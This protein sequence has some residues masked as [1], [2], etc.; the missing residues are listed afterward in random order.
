MKKVLSAIDPKSLADTA[1]SLSKKVASAGTQISEGTQKMVAQ[2]LD[3]SKK[4][5]DS[6]LAQVSEKVMS[7]GVQITDD[8]HHLIE[9]SMKGSKTKIVDTVSRTKEKFVTRIQTTTDTK[10]LLSQ[11]MDGS[12]EKM[13]DTVKTIS[14]KVIDSGVQASEDAKKIVDQSFDATKNKIGDLK[15]LAHSQFSSLHFNISDAA[16]PYIATLHDVIAK[17]KHHFIEYRG[18]TGDL[19]SQGVRH[20]AQYIRQVDPDGRYRENLKSAAAAIG[21]ATVAGYDKIVTASPEFLN[22]SQSLKIKLA[23]AG[24]RDSAWRTIPVAE[25]FYES[26]IPEAVRNLGNDAVVEFLQGKHASHITS[27]HND[28]SQSMADGNIIW[29]SVHEN[30]SRGS[31]NMTGQNLLG[32]ICQI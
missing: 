7:N 16:E 17:G 26:S 31:A 3:V 18:D 20:I 32:G 9:H 8:T 22:L 27:V 28:I 24:L 19:I 1:Q 12:M 29:E 10:N 15:T 6:A 23:T 21:V 11:S 4:K 30:L 2:S 5:I 25:G 14:Q 13:V